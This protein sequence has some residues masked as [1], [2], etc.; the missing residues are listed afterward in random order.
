MRTVANRSSH[1][2][3]DLWTLVSYR[4]S[5]DPTDLA[6]AIEA[7]IASNDLDSR[8]RLLIRDSVRGMEQVW[9]VERF[10]RWLAESAFANQIRE[11]LLTQHDPP[12]FP[13]LARRLMDRTKPETVAQFLREL[14]ARIHQP[15]RVYVGGSISLILSA[16]LSRHT[17]DIDLVDEVPAPLRNEHELLDELSARYGLRLGH[18]QSH[19]LPAG[20]ESRASSY[21]KFGP[22]EVYLV[23]PYDVLVGK[24]MSNRGKDR[25]DLRL[26]LPQLDRSILTARLPSASALL[27][28]PD[29]KKNAVE[30]WYIIFGQPLPYEA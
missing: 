13:S 6:S 21:D 18:F 16:G 28:E 20:W 11:I 23:D 8:T 24:L 4:P 10:G 15:A 17:E 19:F 5:I 29:L 2:P 9:G 26:L 3:T 12:G 14:G 1:P 7:Q 22:L 27:N 25:D 30:N